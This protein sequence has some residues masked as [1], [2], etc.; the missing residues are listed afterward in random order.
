MATP[1]GEQGRLARQLRA[2][3]ARGFRLYSREDSEAGAIIALGAASIRRFLAGEALTLWKL[4]EVDAS[5]HVS[6]GPCLVIADGYLDVA[7]EDLLDYAR[8]SAAAVAN[9]IKNIYIGHCEGGVVACESAAN[10]YDLLLDHHAVLQNG[11]RADYRLPPRALSEVDRDDEYCGRCRVCSCG[12]PGCDS[13]FTWKRNGV[14]MLHFSM[15]GLGIS[16]VHMLPVL[17][18]RPE[19]VYPMD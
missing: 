17:R 4:D 6:D 8:P 7:V 3:V 5:R 19:P 14:V 11:P 15:Y 18:P 16:Q 9:A 13:E 12:D 2:G 1:L 10:L